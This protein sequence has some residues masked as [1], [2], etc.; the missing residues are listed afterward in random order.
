MKVVCS[1]C[2][3]TFIRNHRALFAEKYCN[4]CIKQRILKSGAKCHKKNT[5]IKVLPNGYAYISKY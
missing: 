3:R 1:F 2:G 5:P 4:C